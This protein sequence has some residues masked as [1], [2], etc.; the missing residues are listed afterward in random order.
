MPTGWRIVTARLA[1]VAF[2]VEGARL[3]GGRWNP[4]GVRL[5]YTA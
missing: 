1:E 4:K 5:V 2:T 3:Y